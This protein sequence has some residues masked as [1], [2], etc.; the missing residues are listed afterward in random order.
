MQRAQRRR[1]ELS[2]VPEPLLDPFPI[3]A[4]TAELTMM[5]SWEVHDWGQEVNHSTAGCRGGLG[6]IPAECWF[7]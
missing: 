3:L 1:G 2:E 6:K 7:L 4:V 5:T